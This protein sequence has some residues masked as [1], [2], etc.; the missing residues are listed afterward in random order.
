MKSPDTFFGS[1]QLQ[2]IKAG[3][4][5]AFTELYDFYWEELYD[6]AYK[7]LRRDD[8]CKDIIQEIF[9]DIWNRR[10]S[11]QIENLSAYLHTAVR[12]QVLNY[13]SKTKISAHFVEPFENIEDY[14]L[15]TDA[16]INK[17]EQDFLIEAWAKTLPKKRQ[18]IFLLN[19]IDQLTPKEISVK[20][21]LSQKT[22]HNQLGSARQS[23]RTKF[24]HLFPIVIVWLFLK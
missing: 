19:Q 15:M 14:S 11:L 7:R 8:V 10:E 4:H 23:L 20:L 13:F 16:V 6:N 12:F 9:I 1:N 22:V 5:T 2:M 17:K 21:N 3:S 18:K 24:A